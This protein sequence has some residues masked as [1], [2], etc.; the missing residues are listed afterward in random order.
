MNILVILSEGA[1]GVIEV[2]VGLAAIASTYISIKAYNNTKE[3]EV[4]K[5]SDVI[6][7]KNCVGKK[8]DKSYVDQQDRAI[9]HRIDGIENRTSEDIAH[10]RSMTQSIYDHLLK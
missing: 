6:E 8:A 9:H 3:K 10:I 7:L 4:A 1:K 5:Q 2:G